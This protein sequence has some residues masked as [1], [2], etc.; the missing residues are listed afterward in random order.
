[1]TDLTELQDYARDLQ[2]TYG[3]RDALLEDM[4]AMY[5]LIWDEQSDLEAKFNHMHVTLSPDARNK[6]RTAVRLMTATEPQINVPKELQREIGPDVGDR[7]EQMAAIMLRQ[8]DRIRGNPV[9]YDAVLSGLLFDEIHISVN[10]TAVLASQGESGSK[11]RQARYQRIQDLTPFILDVHSPQGCYADHDALGLT[12]WARVVKMTR[13]SIISRYGSKGEA[14][15]GGLGARQS[16]MEQLDVWAMWTLD[17]Y[18]CWIDGSKEPIHNEKHGLPFIPVAVHTVE[19]SR[20]M[21]ADAAEQRE[22][23]LYTLWKSGLWKRANLYL[24]AMATNAASA[25]WPQ[26]AFISQEREAPDMDLSVPWGVFHLYPNE[27][28]RTW[29]KNL[30]DPALVNLYQQTQALST[31]ST[32]YDQVAG[33]PLGPGASYSETALLN[34]AGRLPLVGIQRKAGWALGDALRM[35]FLLMK[36]GGGKYSGGG[37]A[38]YAEIKAADIPDSLEVEVSMDV[39]LP[40]DRLQLANIIAQLKGILPTEWLL[41]HVL[42]VRQPA[43][44]IEQAM[45]EQATMALWQAEMQRRVQEYMQPQIPAQAGG[46]P[47]MPPGMMPPM[48]GM[49]E[50]MSNPMAGMPGGL[51]PEMGMMG[52]Q[53]PM[54]PA[55]SPDEGQYPIGV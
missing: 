8:S 50:T 42:Q 37:R 22:P 46:M 19:G 52:G 36:D 23:F 47:G 55:G 30:I 26:L 3:E 31:A 48:D 27:D 15:I 11:A 21:F 45:S 40:Q 39:A 2:A 7:I 32:L 49:N 25:L 54:G 35:A 44:L 13:G 6:I 34:Q 38:V 20:A 51:P 29:N 41:E 16:S 5:L 28:L 43:Q 53:G 10:D 1:M 18:A 33:A 14:A 4:K 17:D 24:S 12:A 9:A